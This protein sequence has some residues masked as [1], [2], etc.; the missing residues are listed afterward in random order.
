MS[1]SPWLSVAEEVQDALA[2]G[3]PVVALESTIDEAKVDVMA[4]RIKDINPDCEVNLIEDF[5]GP[6]NMAEYLDQGFDYV[7]DACDSIKAKAGVIYWCKRNK[8]PV[9]TIGGAGGQ[10]DPRPPVGG[11]GGPPP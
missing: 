8:V 4:A 6:H 11:A 5:I 2:E 9:I 10:K 7:I 3:R 1:T